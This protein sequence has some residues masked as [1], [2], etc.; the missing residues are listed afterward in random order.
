MVL[1]CSHDKAAKQRWLMQTSGGLDHG[2][3]AGHHDLD[4]LPTC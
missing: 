1:E 4:D 2:A 3:V